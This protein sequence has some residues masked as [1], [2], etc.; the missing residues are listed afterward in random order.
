MSEFLIGSLI[1]ILIG[2][3]F[4]SE[5]AILWEL[6]DRSWESIIYLLLIFIIRSFVLKASLNLS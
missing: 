1:F 3:S 5:A 6:A 4:L 2:Y